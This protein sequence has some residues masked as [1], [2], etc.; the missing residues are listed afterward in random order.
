MGVPVSYI[1]DSVLDKL[2][3]QAA[4]LMT[5]SESVLWKF[6]LPRILLSLLVGAGLSVS[7]CAFQS[8]FSNPLAT[9]DTL[10]VASG[11]SFGAALALLLGFGML[12]VQ[13]MALFFGIAAV[14]LTH[15][16]GS[17]KGRSSMGMMILSGIMVGSL[18]TALISLIK[19]TADTESQL[20]GHHLL[21]HGQYECGGV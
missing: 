21:A 4:E 13:A 8:L 3:M 2:G 11:T 16:A 15:L 20:A 9:P 18:F 14:A 6:R 7:G 17:G 1:F 19:F 12:G 10:G 5:Q